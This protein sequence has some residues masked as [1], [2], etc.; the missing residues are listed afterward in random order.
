M[1]QALTAPL[2][3][4]DP[5]VLMLSTDTSFACAASGNKVGWLVTLQPGDSFD[6]VS[7]W[8]T[9]HAG[10]AGCRLSV[11]GVTT[12]S[13]F[14]CPDG[15]ISGSCSVSWAD[16]GGTA[17]TLNAW[18]D[19]TLGAVY[20]NNSG[21]P[22]TIAIVF[23]YSGSGNNFGT[24]SSSV[25]L[26]YALNS[27]LGGLG[28]P[29][30]LKNSGGVWQ[31]AAGL[32]HVK[33]KLA[34]TGAYVGGT[35]LSAYNNTA[36][37][38]SVSS[39]GYGSRLDV[40]LGGRIGGVLI[41]ARPASGS[42]FRVVMRKNNAHVSIDSGAVKDYWGASVA[43]VSPIFFPLASPILVRPGDVLHSIMDGTAA[44]AFTTFGKYVFSESA[45]RAANFPNL[46]GAAL[47][48]I[49]S[50][51]ITNPDSVTDTATDMY[52]VIPYYDQLDLATFPQRIA[53]LRGNFQ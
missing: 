31:T 53:N 50:G 39:L 2:L 16:T 33:L 42:N 11:Q 9:A 52:N 48:Y 45:A 35:A 27:I 28:V 10:S 22:Q 7:I 49:N 14:G 29:C 41:A 51:D 12:V 18:N 32:A 37:I 26:S 21:A 6:T 30:G 8:P 34:S 44:T 43:T 13:G 46:Q 25:T 5:R 40:V 1:L 20:T 38:N 4:I 3:P 17:L 24:A 23:D 47:N 15:S 19:K 36:V